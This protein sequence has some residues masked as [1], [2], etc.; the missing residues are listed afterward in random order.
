MAAIKVEGYTPKSNVPLR[1]HK[2]K[3][4]VSIPVDGEKVITGGFSDPLASNFTIS[5]VDGVTLGIK[6]YKEQN[7]IDAI[8]LS[9]V[10]RGA[11]GSAVVD[12]SANL[13]GVVHSGIEE[14]GKTLSGKF[15]KFNSAVYFHNNNAI[16]DFL[17]K[18]GIKFYFRQSTKVIPRTLLVGFIYST[19]AL[20]VCPK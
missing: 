14:L 5:I 9:S 12:Y 15:V 4:Y 20:V 2:D 3:R 16:A 8:M 13:V 10:K 6:G 18:E 7:A 11:S 1:A 19:T 17:T